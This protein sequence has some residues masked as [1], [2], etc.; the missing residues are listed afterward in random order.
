MVLKKIEQQ[1]LFECYS[2]KQMML[3]VNNDGCLK[4][5]SSLM[6]GNSHSSICHGSD[7]EETELELHFQLV[8]D[9]Q[10]HFQMMS[11]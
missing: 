10:K 3:M 2:L 4:Y 1:W 6:P 8:N 9:A 5:V 7:L 11:K